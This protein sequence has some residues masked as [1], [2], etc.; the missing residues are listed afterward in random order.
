MDKRRRQN[1]LKQQDIND[2]V[3]ILQKI[4]DLNIS[5]STLNILLPANN[6]LDSRNT[7]AW[8]NMTVS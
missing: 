8:R 5:D 2:T 7:K 3:Q 6:I 1:V 4:V